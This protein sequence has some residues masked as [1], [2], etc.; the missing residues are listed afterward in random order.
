[1][2]EESKQYLDLNFMD[3]LYEDDMV[4]IV[5]VLVMHEGLNRNQC[6][7]PHNV[8]VDALPTLAN[9]PLTGIPN[10]P[11]LKKYSDDFVE[12][13]RNN[14]DKE[15]TIVFGVFPESGIKNHKFI[16][17]D[18]KVYLKVEAILFKN[19]SPIAMNIIKKRDGNCKISIEISAI[20][21]TNAQKVFEVE[22]FK[23]NSA[24]VLGADIEEGI[25]GSSMNVLRFS[26]DDKMVADCNNR[27]IKF[28]LEDKY[29]IPVK[30]KENAK[31]ALE[32]RKEF[33]RGSTSVGVNM[34]KYLIKNEYAT[35]AK[36]KKIS[37]Y[38]PRHEGD[39]LDEIDPPSNG[40]ISYL[41][42]GGKEARDWSKD[43]VDK[44]ERV[45][46]DLENS[47][48][49]FVAT[50]EVGTK[51]AIKINK[52]KDSLS[53]SEWG[54]VD[55]SELKKECLKA[56][57]Y[58]ELCKAVF[59]KLDDKWEEGIEGSLGYP[60]MEIKDGEAVY[61][62][63][64]LGSAKAY[65]TKNNEEEVLSSLKKIYEELE[66]PWEN[67]NAEEVEIE[68]AETE[69][70]KAE[71]IKTEDAENT[72]EEV[73]EEEK[74]EESKFTFCLNSKQMREVFEDAISGIKYESG[75]YEWNKYYVEAYDE[76]FVYL[77]DC[78]LG[79]TIKVPFVIENNIATI[80]FDSQVKVINAGYMEVGV[81]SEETEEETVIETEPTVEEPEEK[82]DFENKCHALEEKF[83]ALEEKFA[84]MTEKCNAAET[85]VATFERKEEQVRMAELIKE[86]AHCMSSDDIEV[87][88]AK[89]ETETFAELDKAITEKAKEFAKMAKSTEEEVVKETEIKNNYNV[90]FSAFAGTEP[91]NFRKDTTPNDLK[92]IQ[93]KSGVKIN[94]K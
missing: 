87:M 24:M 71:D 50:E 5:E 59:L 10:K 2:S 86:Y 74:M 19:Y 33:G 32:L 81:A 26:L 41:I 85:K 80:D 69:D 15:N 1:M 14:D 64:A 38:F 84:E 25:L 93:Q 52:D 17:K 68:N 53:D 29:K 35:Y 3:V 18:G 30:V 70:V 66:L 20:G 34:A 31:K 61:N 56:E 67:E 58:K 73:G 90:S 40:Y 39:N 42:W 94:I 4:S 48:E 16:E 82:E 46:D 77:C 92:A 9:K 45:G 22:E 88:N 51:E 72:E 28:A 36:V 47:V 11:Y 78:E 79:G 44:K 8:I 27:Y 43:I 7:I 83:K 60:V 6:D 23:F 49:E 89:I 65:A 62:R 13:A 91:F 75:D 12:H 55:K 21:T 76:A 63:S 57:N 54:N 37:Q